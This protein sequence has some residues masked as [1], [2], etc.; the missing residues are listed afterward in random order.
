MLLHVSVPLHNI[1]IY[2]YAF[3]GTIINNNV[4][5]VFNFIHRYMSLYNEPDFMTGLVLFIIIIT[6]NLP[7]LI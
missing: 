1:Y 2:I 6:F 4:F 5:S 7:K 3:V